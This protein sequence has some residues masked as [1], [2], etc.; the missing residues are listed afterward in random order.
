MTAPFSF[1]VIKE[2]SMLPAFKPG[3]RVLTFNWSRIK[4]G[5]SVVFKKRN[6]YYVKRVV[7]INKGMVAIAGDNKA[8]SSKMGPI[9]NDQI[10]G[11]VIWSG[12]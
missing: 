4:S 3:D 10:V 1:F 7:G 5:S 2:E 8:K 11:R 6:K 12:S 9:K